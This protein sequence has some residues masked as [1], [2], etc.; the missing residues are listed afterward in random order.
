MNTEFHAYT[1]IK[2]GEVHFFLKN[3]QW[4]ENK[5]ILL[6]LLEE[7]R[8]EAHKIIMKELVDLCLKWKNKTNESYYPIP[9]GTA[10]HEYDLVKNPAPTTR[11]TIWIFDK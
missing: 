10:Y 9:A 5:V 2:K 11:R 3:T 7:D 1:D 4:F 6:E 8:Q